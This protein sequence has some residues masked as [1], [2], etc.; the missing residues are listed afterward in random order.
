MNNVSI[1]VVNI[2]GQTIITKTNVSGNRFGIDISNQAQGIY[3]IEVLS[4]DGIWR[5]KVVKN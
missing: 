4:S 1:K 2:A 3:F 5:G